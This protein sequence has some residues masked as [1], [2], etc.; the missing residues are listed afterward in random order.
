GSEFGDDVPRA[1]Q[2]GKT[3]LAVEVVSISSIW[4]QARGPLSLLSTHERKHG[5]HEPAQDRQG[6]CK[7]CEGV[8]EGDAPLVQEEALVGRWARPH[9]NHRGGSRRRR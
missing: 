7:G 5:G 9:L 8:R 1:A 3:M 4:R 6:G 2:P